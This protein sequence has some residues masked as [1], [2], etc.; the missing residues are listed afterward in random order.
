MVTGEVGVVEL[1]RT[2]REKFD[3]TDGQMATVE[4]QLRDQTVVPKPTTCSA[5]RLR[6]RDD[7][8]VLASAIAGAV[9]CW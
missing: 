9:E 5:T 1:R 2:L 6:D 8:W 3:A 7:E 4:G